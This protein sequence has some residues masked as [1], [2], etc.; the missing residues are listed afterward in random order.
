MLSWSGLLVVM[1]GFKTTSR[2]VTGTG[3][4]HPV[5]TVSPG[6]IR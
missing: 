5:E 3:N 6:I 4:E 2:F 1:C